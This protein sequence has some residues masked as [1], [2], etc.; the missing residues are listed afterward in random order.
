MSRGT[1]S[2]RIWTTGS[3]RIGPSATLRA[4]AWIA[5]AGAF[6]CSGGPSPAA[7]Q[8]VDRHLALKHDPAAVEHTRFNFQERYQ[9]ELEPDS[10]VYG[11]REQF[12][13]LYPPPYWEKRFTDVTNEDGSL[14]WRV[15][16]DAMALITLFDATGDFE[17]LRRVRRYADAAMEARDDHSGAIDEDGRSEPGWSTPRYGEGKRRVYLVHSGLILQPIL[18]WARRAPRDPEWTEQDEEIRRRRIAQCEQTALYHDY[19]IVDDAPSGW[20]VYGTGR[21]ER[22]RQFRWQPFNRQT[23]VARNFTLLADLTGKEEYRERARRLYRFFKD[24]LASAEGSE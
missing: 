20:L 2:S 23:L 17:L 5:L 11:T 10:L 6:S 22:E 9:Y 15:S 24:H 14:A 19:Q 7:A 1:T 18:E 3:T 4:L 21:E 8:Q 13:R 12:D 16:R